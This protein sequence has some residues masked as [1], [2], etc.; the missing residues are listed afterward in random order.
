MIIPFTFLFIGL[1]YFCYKTKDD[2]YEMNTKAPMEN[3]DYQG[4]EDL[5]I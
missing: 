5:F 2:I 1:G 3:E 4:I